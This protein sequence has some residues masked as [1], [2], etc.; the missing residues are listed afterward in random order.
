MTTVKEIIL[1]R[2][3]ETVER[4]E[5]YLAAE[6]AILDG[7]QSYTIGSRT[8]TRGDLKAITSQIDRLEKKQLKL[9]GNGAI[10]VQRVVPRD[11]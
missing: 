6:Q 8:L 3:T 10:R 11:I 4:L 9:L 7:A 2:Y 5:K 1:A